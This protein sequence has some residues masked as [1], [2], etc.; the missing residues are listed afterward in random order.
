[1]TRLLVAGAGLIG[2]RHI[3]HILAQPH[4]TLAGVIDP[5]PAV[6]AKFDAPAFASIDAVDVAAD[7]I[8]LATPS[9][10]HADHAEQSAARGWH[11]LIEKPVASAMEQADRIIAAAR[12]AEVRTLVGH[13]RRYHPKVR[14]L[15]D[16]LCGGAIGTPVLASLIWALKKPDAYFD[17][18]WRAGVQ[19]SPVLINLVHEVDL[20]RFLFGTITNVSGFG[21][22]NVR[23]KK[24][25]E[26]G[27]VTLGFSGGQ[28][29]TIAFSDA[30]PSP[31]AFEAGTGENPNIAITAQDHL[32]IIG[33]AGAVEFPS[34]TVWSGANDWSQSPSPVVYPAE[35][36]A[37]LIVQL[38]H[39]SDVIAG[40]DE[41]LVDAEEGRKSLEH[42]LKIERVLAE[43][44]E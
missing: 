35:G 22:R 16:L 15:K 2:S 10:L 12:A 37:P 44:A 18:S 40:R 6:R 43:S 24:N 4:L 14:A 27:G 28:V 32:R 39:F 9:D 29:A 31:W 26:S 11:M 30:T 13:H 7:G 8:V 17:V 21:S 42:T 20:L 3:A 41:P 34:L 25:L 38:N 36:E 1:M 23:G 5:D 19:G 33:T